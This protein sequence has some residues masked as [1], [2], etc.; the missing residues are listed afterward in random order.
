MS[1]NM[2]N[3]YRK[4]LYDYEIHNG[5]LVT[6]ID[7]I[8]RKLIGYAIVNKITVTK[9]HLSYFYESQISMF[10]KDYDYKPLYG[11]NPYEPLP[12][13]I[14]EMKEE[15]KKHGYTWDFGLI[16]KTQWK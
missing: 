5:D 10:R 14:E 6:F 13:D 15:M 9:M 4:R 12:Q 8:Y 2:E 11:V 1:R 16:E 3:V 7:D